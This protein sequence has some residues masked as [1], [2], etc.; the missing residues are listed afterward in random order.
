MVMI[1]AWSDAAVAAAHHCRLGL[2]DRLDLAVDL[3][4]REDHEAG[5]VQP[6]DRAA[7]LA[8]AT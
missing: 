7:A 1:S 3:V 6:R 8:S 2:D 5:H 4:H